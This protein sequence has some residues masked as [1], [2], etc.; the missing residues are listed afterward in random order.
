MCIIFTWQG[1]KMIEKNNE[2]HVHNYEETY[3]SYCS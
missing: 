1:E 2:V 3:K